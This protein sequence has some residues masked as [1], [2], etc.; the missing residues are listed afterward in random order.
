[1]PPPSR[2]ALLSLLLLSSVAHAGPVRLEVSEASTKLVRRLTFARPDAAHTLRLGKGRLRVATRPAPGGTAEVALWA[3]AAAGG[4]EAL[5]ARLVLPSGGKGQVALEAHQALLGPGLGVLW[6]RNLTP[7]PPPRPLTLTGH[8]LDLELLCGA[9]VEA[10]SLVLLP[11]TRAELAV[12]EGC[13][14]A[15]ARATVRLRCARTCEGAVQDASGAALA[16]LSGTPGKLALAPA[17]GAPEWLARARL[18]P[19]TGQAVRVDG[20]AVLEEPLR[21]DVT[22]PGF[23][24][25]FILEPP[26]VREL[27]SPQPGHHGKRLRVQVERATDAAAWLTVRTPA[28]AT[29]LRT[30]MRVGEPAVMP[31]E[32]TDGW[33]TGS[34]QLTLKPLRDLSILQGG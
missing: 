3:R 25:T 12:P 28:G 27:E 26:E 15:G 4:E 2:W 29:V 32:G 22:H 11:D 8:A 9:R 13:P 6:V 30:R 7:R 34:L 5:L 21:L 14:G 33:C 17:A 16:Q 19:G 23:R 24:S 31:C 10:V 1:M 20:T 18:T